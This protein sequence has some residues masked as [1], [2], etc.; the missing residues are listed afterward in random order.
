MAVDL[1]A[2]RGAIEVLDGCAL[3]G[4]DAAGRR[5]VMRQVRSARRELDGLTATLLRLER[6]SNGGSPSGDD[7]ALGSGGVS[8]REARREHA[9]SQ[10]ADVLPVVGARFEAGALEPEKV[11]ALARALKRL[12]DD[13]DR[14]A[15]HDNWLAS[16]AADR[17][18]DQFCGDV[19]S[20]V[21]A[22]QD[23]AGDDDLEQQVGKSSLRQWIGEDGMGHTHLTLDPVRHAELETQIQDALS[24]LCSEPGATRS[25]NSAA[26]ALLSLVSDGVNQ[27]GRAP[28][29]QVTVL[30]DAE[31]L[32]R[33][34]H[35]DTVSETGNGTPIP[36]SALD[37]F[38][39]DADIHL[40]L[41]GPGG[42]VDRIAAAKR[43]ATAQQRRL[44]RAMYPTCAHPGCDVTFDRC[45]VHHLEHWADGGPTVLGNLLPLCSQHHHLEHDAGWSYRLGPGRMLV[46]LRPDG[47]EHARCRLPEPPALPPDLHA[48][49]PGRA[50]RRRSRATGVSGVSS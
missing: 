9:R 31:T 25:S 20:L 23:D 49:Q 18:V 47:S 38:L 3:D 45:Q 37:R 32:Q 4:L 10:V 13:A 5:R 29:A 30:V 43:T 28:R 34:H 16:H 24:R 8:G 12:D 22:L 46:V 14:L 48:R 21:T 35:A 33:G 36:P 27:P 15:E 19:R 50:R 44:L 7:L 2:M 41:Q 6:E 40:A 11:D 1:G 42:I 26:A 17:T 39:C